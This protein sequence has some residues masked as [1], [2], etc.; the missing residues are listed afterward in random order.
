MSKTGIIITLIGIGLFLI[1]VFASEGYD[2][3]RTIIGNMYSME[4]VI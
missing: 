2:Q 4:V 1:S 3:Q